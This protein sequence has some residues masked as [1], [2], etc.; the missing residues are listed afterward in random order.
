MR[1]L[2]LQM[3]ITLDGYVAGSQGQLDWM[4][5]ETDERQVQYLK[6]LTT[7]MDTILLGRKMAEEAVPHW[8]HVTKIKKGDAEWEYAKTFVSTPKIIF[9][10][11]FRSPLGENTT[12]E[13]GDLTSVVTKLKDLPGKDIIVYGGASF[14]SALIKQ[15]L[16]DEFHLLVNPVAIGAGKIIFDGQHKLTLIKSMAFS[17]GVVANQYKRDQ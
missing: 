9:S 12:L 4:T 5:P 2:K 8:E 13:Q 1:K 3:Q 7:S 14:A 17:N 11:T 16:V 10:K 6:D 15:N